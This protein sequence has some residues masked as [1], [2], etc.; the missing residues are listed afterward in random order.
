VDRIEVQAP[1][2]RVELFEDRA[3]VTRRVAIPAE[4]GRHHL[5]IPGL[6]PLVREAGLSFLGDENTIVEE[7]RVVRTRRRPEDA[8]PPEAAALREKL[9]ALEDQVQ[10]LEEAARR[11]WDHAER[12]E[13]FADAGRNWA[14]LA[15]LGKHPASEWANALRA[16]EQAS[17]EASLES[18][19]QKLVLQ[20]LRA[21][22]DD[23]E[24][25]LARAREGRSQLMARLEIQVLAP[26]GG[27]LEV[28]YTI[29]C[30][31]WRPV[32]RARLIGDRLSWQV[33]AMAWNA[34]GEDW[35]GV[36]L[37]CS[38]ARPSGRANAPDL[39]DDVLY[40]RKRHKEVV[41]EARDEVI[42]VAREGTKRSTDE[43]PGVDDGGEPR[44]YTAPAPVD[45]D[46]DGRP[47][48]ILLERWEA[49]AQ[50]R[51]T[52]HPE[53]SPHVVFQSV[54][55]NAGTRPLLAG[56]VELYRES[57]AVG[58]GKVGLVPPGEPFPLGWGSHDEIRLARRL[59]HEVERSRITGRQTHKFTCT[60][61]IVHL[62]REPLTVT[63]R[64][65][66]PVSEL[67]EVKVTK[68]K[69]RPLLQEGPDRDGICTWELTLE[70][71]AK[72]ELDLSYSVE[73][74]SSVKLP[75]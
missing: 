32:H 44:T 9:E 1:P 2:R 54:Q 63:I 67:K 48:Y 16:L 15:L 14:P 45:L 12:A 65:R 13:Q 46:S 59:D 22:R 49:N 3:S 19:E 28:Q 20:D 42:E 57:G 27:A 64:E 18:S 5:V 69:A 73:A 68:P 60:S 58:R 31:L 70:P 11:A 30:A 40:A 61:R 39:T 34:T 35:K 37:V 56:P 10:R 7:A 41:I 72:Q 25:R 75:W 62:G 74:T 33:A 21:E 66:I 71:G 36:E 55:V 24:R 38:T 23:L 8:D 52:A 4:A 17:S 47:V 50:A 6:S 51:W 53:R 26:A 29:P 43:V